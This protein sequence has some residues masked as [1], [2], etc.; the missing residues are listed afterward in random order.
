MTD[1]Q[2]LSFA[3]KTGLAER[4][5]DWEETEQKRIE[6]RNSISNLVSRILERVPDEDRASMTVDSWW[7]TT[8]TESGRPRNETLETATSIDNDLERLLE[9]LD[10][11]SSAPPATFTACPRHAPSRTR[12]P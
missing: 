1:Q 4:W 2:H 10:L 9:V 11:R 6:R 8:E 5:R 3:L 12:Y 7:K